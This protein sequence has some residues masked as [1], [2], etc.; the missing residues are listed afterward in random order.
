[1][2][3]TPFLKWAGGKRWFTQRYSHLLPKRYS[4]YIEPF[5]GS[6]SVFFHLQP[7]QA[8]LGDSNP[9]VISAFQGMKEDWV[10]L[11]SRLLD[12]QR[13]HSNAHYY[14]VRSTVPDDKTEQAARIIYL[15]RACFNG[16]YRVNRHGVFNVPRGTRDTIVFDGEDFQAKAQLLQGAQIHLA[17][18]ESLIDDARDGDLVFADP[19]YTVRHN[20]NGFVKYN[21]KLFAWSDQERLA[22]AL[23]RAYARGAKIVCTNANHSS[24]RELYAD[25][26]FTLLDV[27]RFSPISA[28]ADSRKPFEELVIISD[29]PRE[30]EER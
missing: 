12:H 11:R 13:L 3:M 9:D 19:P 15:N 18:F 5:L 16:I 4:R 14:A 28:S 23:F 24:I 26:G 17:D 8:V 22:Y 6:G 1:M 30:G 20:L 2:I 10:Q 21:E 29:P 27:S 25:R 7:Q